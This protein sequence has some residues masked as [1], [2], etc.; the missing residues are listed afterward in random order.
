MPKLNLRS[1]FLILSVVILLIVA[2]GC[3]NF[4]SNSLNNQEIVQSNKDPQN[5]NI[6]I[7]ELYAR[8]STNITT[9]NDGIVILRAEPYF[10][11]GISWE[12][13]LDIEIKD[14]KMYING[15]LYEESSSVPPVIIYSDSFLAMAA[16]IDEN[17]NQEITD[18]LQKIKNCDSSYLIETKQD[19]SAGELISIYEIEGAYYF[20]RFYDNG[21]VM[22][23]HYAPV[24]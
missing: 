5:S 10:N 14:E 20:V 8:L 15:V 6:E 1:L 16:V 2:V 23:I 17:Y 21:E 11:P 7:S 18:I 24:E 3:S 9:E 13:S 19:S 4:D 12:Y 22:R